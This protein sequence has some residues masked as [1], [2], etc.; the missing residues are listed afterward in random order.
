MRASVMQLYTTAALLA[1][2]S[3][4]TLVSGQDYWYMSKWK[5]FRFDKDGPD[6]VTEYSGLEWRR[7]SRQGKC[8]SLEGQDKIRDS[9]FRVNVE[10]CKVRASLLAPMLCCGAE[11]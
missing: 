2:C 1:A 7:V 11:K 9:K 10:Q 4:S 3:L 8:H 6:V 5:D